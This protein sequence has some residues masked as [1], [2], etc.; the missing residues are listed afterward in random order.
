MTQTIVAPDTQSP[1]GSRMARVVWAKAAEQGMDTKVNAG[2]VEKVED[3]IFAT[4]EA[5]KGRP[6]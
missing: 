2:H 6:P 1:E 5:W 4:R 3:N